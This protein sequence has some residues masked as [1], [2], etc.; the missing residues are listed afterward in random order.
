ML[1][2]RPYAD[3]DFAAVSALWDAC[4]LTRPWNDHTRDIAFCRASPNAELL[5][6]VDARAIVASVMVGHDGH[7]GAVYYVAVHP[8]H[9]HRGFGRTIM[10]QAEDWLCTRGVWK[11]N[12]MIRA[13]NADVQ[14]FYESIGYETEPRV[15]MTRR[16]EPKTGDAS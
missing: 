3:K 5:V 4:E 15:A 13:D 7:R 6:G 8:D 14:A 2:V 11:L 12:L 10:R 16:L 1:T 9:R